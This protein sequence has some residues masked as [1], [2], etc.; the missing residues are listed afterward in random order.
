MKNIL[1]YI[2]K[3][4][5]KYGSS[6]DEAGSESEGTDEAEAG[7]ESEDGIITFDQFKTS[8]ME[9]IRA[10]AVFL[11][12]FRHYCRFE[13]LEPCFS[14][15]QWG[16][17]GSRWNMLTKLC[18]NIVKLVGGVCF[19]TNAPVDG[20]SNG[21]MSSFELDHLDKDNKGGVDPSR[22]AEKAG[23]A[24]KLGKAVGLLGLAVTSSAAHHRGKD[25]HPSRGDHDAMKMQSLFPPK[26]LC[27]QED[28]IRYN[29]SQSYVY[30]HF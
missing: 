7:S 17:R 2:D 18:Q 21:A 26:P 13:D 22:I 28:R 5:T 8:I 27:D 16:N 6:T 25:R 4:R 1:K 30:L 10:A 14:A 11:P 19:Q 20:G 23:G 9:K 12:V 3:C 24:V 15:E 29:V